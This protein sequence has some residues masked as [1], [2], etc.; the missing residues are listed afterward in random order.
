MVISPLLNT[1]LYAGA[2]ACVILFVSVLGML[3]YIICFWLRKQKTDDVRRR[4]VHTHNDVHKIKR[5]LNIY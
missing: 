1:L 4:I 2:I 5:R 3:T